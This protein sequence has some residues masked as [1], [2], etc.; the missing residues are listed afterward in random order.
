MPRLQN[1][2]VRTFLDFVEAKAIYVE[3]VEEAF[4]ILSVASPMREV[5]VK[6]VIRDYMDGA[7]YEEEKNRLGAVPGFMG[8]L[9]GRLFDCLKTQGLCVSGCHCQPACFCASAQGVEQLIVS[10]ERE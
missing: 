5:L 10:E 2:A 7:Y 3:A 6:E 4:S 8:T 1:D 9:T